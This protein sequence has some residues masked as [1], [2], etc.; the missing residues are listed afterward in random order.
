[1]VKVYY[2]EKNVKSNSYLYMNYYVNTLSK[3]QYQYLNQ[4][5]S[6]YLNINLCQYLSAYNVTV[7]NMIESS[8]WQFIV[9]QIKL[10]FCLLNESAHYIYNYVY[11]CAYYMTVTYMITT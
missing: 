6:K 10:W 11:D 5:I 4:S 9:W 1:M 2:V 3:Y 8:I 7:T